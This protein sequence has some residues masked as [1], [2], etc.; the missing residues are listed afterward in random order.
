MIRSY[1]HCCPQKNAQTLRN[2]IIPAFERVQTDHL[3]GWNRDR[4]TFSIVNFNLHRKLLK[5]RTEIEEFLQRNIR[6]K[7]IN[8]GADALRSHSL[9][10]PRKAD[11]CFFGC[12]LIDTLRK[13]FPNLNQ[14]HIND[15]ADYLFEK[16]FIIPVMKFVRS[17]RANTVLYRFSTDE[18]IVQDQL[19]SERHRLL[20]LTMEIIKT[21]EVIPGALTGESLLDTVS[22]ILQQDY[23][24]GLGGLSGKIHMQFLLLHGFIYPE[25][26]RAGN[27][28]QFQVFSTDC[29]Y[30]FRDF[31]GERTTDL[32]PIASQVSGSTLSPEPSSEDPEK[33]S[34]KPRR[35]S[36]L[37]ISHFPTLV[38]KPAS[39]DDPRQA[40]PSRKISRNLSF[41]KPES[42]RG[43]TNSSYQSNVAHQSAENPVQRSKS[44][45][46]TTNTLTTNHPLRKRSKALLLDFAVIE[47]DD[48]GNASIVDPMEMKPALKPLEHNY[49]P[50]PGNYEL[51]E[52]IDSGRFGNIYLCR[53]KPSKA[54]MAVKQVHYSPD[55]KKPQERF[56]ALKNEL[57]ILKTV[58]YRHIVRYY[59]FD[60]DLDRGTFNIFMEYVDG[61]SMRRYIQVNGAL[62]NEETEES[63]AHVLLGLSYLHRNHIIHRDLKGANVLRSADGVLKIADF[64]CSKKFEEENE[65][66][67]TFSYAG[68]PYWMCP[69]I[70]K[71]KGYNNKCDVWSLGATC[72]EFLTTKP[73]YFDRD[74]YPAMMKIARF[75]MRDH[76][77]FSKNISRDLKVLMLR[78]FEMDPMYRPSVDEILTLP[79]FSSHVFRRRCVFY[80]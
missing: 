44:D 72:F 32:D 50:L 13:G 60:D 4:N 58:E 56:K 17:F 74:A 66:N 26:V 25:R 76:L 75:P 63:L 36:V 80:M 20:D 49:R 62:S 5:S 33:I 47:V 7:M 42:A 57:E 30:S 70:I 34:T 68:T 61:G 67:K 40:G 11:L 12:K 2:P 9:F 39:R 71:C 23:L 53:D 37:T 10:L 1:D 24:I 29:D 16:R 78:C 73:P 35:G 48:D 19:V 38:L 52:M 65:E 8:K 46:K 3:K 27:E 41:L 6:Q 79:M 22:K 45:R 21:F 14:N 59:G 54:I 64:G 55:S 69:E 15:L 51:L 77:Q 43:S 31:S 28:E 18:M